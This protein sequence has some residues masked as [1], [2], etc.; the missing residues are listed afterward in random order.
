MDVFQ[1]TLKSKNNFR[2]REWLNKSYHF[3]IIKYWEASNHAMKT[4][5]LK[6]YNLML[7]F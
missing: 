4:S 5:I 6:F 3:H 2:A 1:S 7:K